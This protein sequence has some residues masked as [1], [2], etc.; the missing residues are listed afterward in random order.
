MSKRKNLRRIITSQEQMSDARLLNLIVVFSGGFQ[1]AYTFVVR[2]RVFANAQTGN[3]V[4]M[5]TH[6]LGGRWQQGL[7]YLFPVLAFMLGVFIAD[8]IEHRFKHSK[9]MHWRQNIVFAE[10]VI[11]F[12]VGL[13]P[14]EYNMI[15]NCMVSFACAMQLYSFKKINGNAY[16]STM[17]IGNMKSFVIAL[18]AYLRT[19]KG[20]DLSKTFNYFLVIIIFSIGAG[21]GGNFSEVF[22]EKTIWC[23]AVLLLISFLMMELDRE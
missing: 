5:S 11:M 22:N 23:S 7:R 3:L 16:A 6:L 20:S 9:R 14:Q 13:L 12:V 21:I 18:S 19:K 8:N 15:A 2:G 10:A 4:L 17:C 1:D